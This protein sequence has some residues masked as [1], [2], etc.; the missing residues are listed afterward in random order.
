MPVS[1][2]AALHGKQGWV[3]GLQPSR[4]LTLTHFAATIVSLVSVCTSVCMCHAAFVHVMSGAKTTHAMCC[5]RGQPV[6]IADM[7]STACSVRPEL[8]HVLGSHAEQGFPAG[9]GPPPAQVLPLSVL[10]TSESA[11]PEMWY[12]LA[13]APAISQHPSGWLGDC[14]PRQG[15]VMWMLPG[16]SVCTLDPRAGVA[17]RESVQGKLSCEMRSSVST[18]C[19]YYCVYK[20]V[21]L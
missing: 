18:A 3:T 6:N 16:D 8:Q 14:S 11:Q 4:R 5:I 9:G 17:L 19:V 20:A 21:M 12:Q 10:S 13:T 15:V 1:C 2:W 7:Q